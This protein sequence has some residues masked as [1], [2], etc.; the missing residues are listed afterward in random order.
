MHKTTTLM[1]LL[2]TGGLLLGGLLLGGLLGGCAS[3]ETAPHDE[4]PAL[5]REDVAGQSGYLAMALAEIGPLALEYGGK[6]DS[7]DGRYQSFFGS[8]QIQ[9]VVELYFETA[10]EPSG[11]QT[12]DFASAWTAEGSPLLIFP[13]PGGIAWLLSFTLDSAIDQGAGTA[14]VSGSGVLA[15]GNYEAT[16][17]VEGLAVAANGDWPSEGLLSFTNEGFTATVTFDGDATATVAVGEA[18]WILNLENGTLTEL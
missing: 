3:D 15:V 14:V 7:S 11:Y 17:S 10:G 1:T 4:L 9:G 5:E 8:A 2:L 18:S 12:A 16:W 13:L 6:A